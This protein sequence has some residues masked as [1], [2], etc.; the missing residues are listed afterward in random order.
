MKKINLFKRL[1]KKPKELP[2][3]EKTNLVGVKKNN[4]KSKKIE[5]LI[6]WK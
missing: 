5:D 4:V 3:K 1:K 6:E 2:E